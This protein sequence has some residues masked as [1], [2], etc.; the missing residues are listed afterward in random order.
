MISAVL[1]A[2]VLY[3]APIRDLLLSLAADDFFSP[4]WSATI[5]EEWKR[6]LLIKR[7]DLKPEKLERTTLLMNQAFPNA[8]VEDYQKWIGAISLKDPDD[9]H[10]AA[11]AIQANADYI[12]TINLKDFVNLVVPTGKFEVIHPD[13]F[14]DRLISE[15]SEAVYRGFEKMVLRLKNPP[16]SKAEVLASLSGCGLVATAK[17]LK[18]MGV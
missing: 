13:D 16:Q 12:I 5:Q 8:M 17:K 6:N 2:N 3:P 11:V 18:E 7:Q 9:R 15:D 1:D 14:I 4:L 10:V